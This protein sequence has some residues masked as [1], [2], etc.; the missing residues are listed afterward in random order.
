MVFR[1]REDYIVGER[2]F[3]NGHCKSNPRKMIKLWAEKEFRNLKRIEDVG[4]NCP[5]AMEL[6]DNLI[7]MEFLGLNKEAAPRYYFLTT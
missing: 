6:R 4:M 7:V 1:D 2:R 3:K 5:K